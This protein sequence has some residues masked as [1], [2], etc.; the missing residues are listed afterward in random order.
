MNR[1]TAYD[2]NGKEVELWSGNH[3]TPSGSA[4]GISVIPVHP[5]FDLTRVRIYVDSPRVAGWNE[6]DAVGPLDAAG[7]THWAKSATASSTYA[8]VPGDTGNPG[9]GGIEPLAL[10]TTKLREG[11][12]VWN[13]HLQR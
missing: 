5:E 7:L 4:K 11:G 2:A 1:V 12:N 10:P 9:G 6:I 8:E 13:D 3:P